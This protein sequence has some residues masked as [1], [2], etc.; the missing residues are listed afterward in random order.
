MSLPEFPSGS[1]AGTSSPPG[2]KELQLQGTRPPPLRVSKDS[3]TIH[4]TRKPPLP[5]NAHLPQPPPENR[6]P[7]IIYTVSP[8]VLHVTVSDFMNVVQRLTG[9]SSG[10][11]PALRPGDVSPAARLASIERTSPSERERDHGGDEDV[12]LMLEGLDV[13]QFPGILS[14]ATLPQIAPGFFNEPQ[15][16]T[17]F[18]HD[19]S[20]FW[21]THSFVA[22]PSGLFSASAISPLASPNFFNLFD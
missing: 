22:S 18:W 10:D 19:L 11:E 15:T 21:S 14:P 13:G 16:A 1:G 17:S 4:K 7:V 5:P 6:K 2:K 8:K 12:M 9:P 3:H 20:P